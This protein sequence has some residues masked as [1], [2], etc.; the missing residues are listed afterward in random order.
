MFADDRE[1]DVK[2]VEFTFMHKTIDDFWDWPSS[3]DVA[4]VASGFIFY[5]PCIPAAPTK[6]GFRFAEEDDAKKFYKAFR[7][8]YRSSK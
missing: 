6:K 1:S 4:T 2:E 5:G 8:N 3:E 7:Y